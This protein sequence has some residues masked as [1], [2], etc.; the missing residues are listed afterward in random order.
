MNDNMS[1]NSAG[2]AILLT[3]ILIPALGAIV[4]TLVSYVVQKQIIK[5][6]QKKALL[7]QQKAEQEKTEYEEVEVVEDSIA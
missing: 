5:A 1:K 2:K 6:E 3:G 7:E 4:S